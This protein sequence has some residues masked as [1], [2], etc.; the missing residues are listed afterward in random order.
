[1]SIERCIHAITQ[2]QFDVSVDAVNT[3]VSIK[4]S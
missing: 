3:Q 4:L 1:M 2:P